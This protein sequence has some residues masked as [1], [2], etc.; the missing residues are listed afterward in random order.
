M[1]CKQCGANTQL[2]SNFCPYCGAENTEYKLHRKQ[3]FRMKKDYEETR[4]QVLE[5]NQKIATSFIRIAVIACLVALN[6]F[7]WIMAGNAWS[8]MYDYKVS[9]EKK[10]IELHR[11]KL[12]EYEKDN[13]YHM[14]QAYYE[15]RNIGLIEDLEEFESVCRACYNYTYVY[16]LLFDLKNPDNFYYREEGIKNIC[17][18]LEYMYDAI[19]LKE[20]DDPKEFEGQHKITMEN[21]K[22]D[23]S[24]LLMTYGGISRQ[25]AENF[26]SM[27]DGQRQVALERGL[28]LYED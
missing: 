12:T 13:N 5:E 11:K 23:V 3:I 6:L 22:K 4:E 18:S 26:H 17:D 7:V 21:L 8:I 20:Y 28:G 25:E 15:E 1:K 9:Q 24:L 27:S 10:Y 14:L 19:T 2:E 16:K